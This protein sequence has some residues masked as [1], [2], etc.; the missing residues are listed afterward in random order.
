MVVNGER[1]WL[2]QVQPCSSP[3]LPPSGLI[4]PDILGQCLHSCTMFVETTVPLI[5]FFLYI[6]RSLTDRAVGRP[7]QLHEITFFSSTSTWSPTRPFEST[8]FPSSFGLARSRSRTTYSLLP[9]HRLSQL[10][11]VASNTLHKFST[12]LQASVYIN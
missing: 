5:P 12:F 2:M 6:N 8:S 11:S 3:D 10:K 4:E 9:S 1:W 7:V